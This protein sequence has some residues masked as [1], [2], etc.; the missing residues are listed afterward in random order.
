MPATSSLGVMWFRHDLRL[1]DNPALAAL[2]RC[3]DAMVCV[4][5]ID[6][7]WF[8][9]THFHAAP[10]GVHRQRFLRQSLEALN[11][12]LQERGQR[13]WVIEGQPVE[14][15]SRLCQQFPVTHLACNAHCG[16][17]ERQQ[18]QR[19]KHTLAGVDCLQLQGHS[20][21]DSC[22]LPFA[23]DK[24]PSQFTPFRHKVSSCQ[25]HAPLSVPSHLPQGVSTASPWQLQA[26]C[27]EAPVTRQW[28]GGET[29][30]LQHLSR[31]LGAS[32]AVRHYKETRNGLLGWDYSSKLSPWLA[33]G[34]VSVRRVADELFAHEQ[35]YGENPSTQWLYFELLW[36]E[37]FYWNAWRLQGD[38]FC[39]G[40][41]R[42]RKP[43]TTFMAERFARW[44]S[45]STAYATVNAAM[46]EL[47]QTGYLSNR[48]RQWAASAL[49]HELGLDWRY[50]AAYFEQQLLDYD[51]ASNWGNWQYLAG[52]GA[53]PRGHR[54]FD[55]QKQARQYDPDGAYVHHWQSTGHLQGDSVDASDWPVTSS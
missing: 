46:C 4:Y 41:E 10:M 53:D 38:L 12:A 23:T 7:R 50:G 29:A 13:L 2:S 30:A 25:P 35:R 6:P 20:L 5:V 8:R 51:V 28:Q 19:L 11:T 15:I 27:A 44:R 9:P 22:D 37:F 33:N 32:G 42:G 14:A 21:F 45:G 24:V 34:C 31:Y 1:H 48:A 39:F 54:H 52:V 18:W 3:V 47:N 17:Y 26:L 36:R 40:G 43:L 49:V 16:V 55:L